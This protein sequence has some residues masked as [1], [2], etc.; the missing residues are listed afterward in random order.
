[1]KKPAYKMVLFGALLV[2]ALTSSCNN[3]PGKRSQSDPSGNFS[4]VSPGIYRGG[5][6]DQPG[7]EVD[8]PKLG[9]KTIIDLENDDE[10]I[11]NE[12]GWAEKA[13]IT[14][15]S[16][17]MNGMATPDDKEVTDILA[18]IDADKPVFVHCMQG[19]DRTGLIVA[20]YRVFYEK[21][22]PKEAHDEMIALGFHKILIAMHS[23][24]ENRTHWED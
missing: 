20:L 1:M 7:V 12:K 21:W 10:A 23:Y 24:F 13:G 9:V 22:T 4:E 15:V 16:R 5:R 8:L 19:Q 14:F 2:A 17:P 11:A 3:V 18:Q 6:P